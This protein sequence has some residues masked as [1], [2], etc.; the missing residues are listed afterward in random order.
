MALSENEIDVNMFQHSTYLKKFKGEHSLELDYITE[1]PTAAMGI[2]SDKYKTLDEVPNGAEIAVPNYDTNYARALR[3]FAQTGL[4]ALDPDVDP[5]KSTVGDI[6]ENPKGF[7]FK[8]VSAEVL[9]S[10]L[11]SVGLAI[12]NGNY[13]IGAGLRLDEA[14]YN[15]ELGEG[16]YNVIA[17][18]SEDVESQFAKDIVSIVHSDGFRSVIEDSSKQYVAFARPSGYND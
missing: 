8:E 7:T 13:A 16:Y 9:P 18:R 15:E 10:V 12:I 14:V 6:S 2:F 5:S 3:V 4:I 1:I 17:V 11:D